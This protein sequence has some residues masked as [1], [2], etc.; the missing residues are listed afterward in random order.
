[1]G[2]R[3]CIGMWIG[4]G[5]GYHTGEVGFIIHVLGV[6]DT[7]VECRSHTNTGLKGDAGMRSR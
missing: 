4:I 3:I 6:S 7:V 5:S 1:M 2:I